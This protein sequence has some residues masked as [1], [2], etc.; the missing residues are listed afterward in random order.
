MPG[1]LI[2][3]GDTEFADI[4]IFSEILFDDWEITQD[5][6]G[7][8]DFNNNGTTKLQLLSTGVDVIGNLDVSGII[9][10]GT[11][12][13]SGNLDMN[14]NDIIDV[15]NINVNTGGDYLFNS[16]SVLNNNTLGNGVINSSL[17][18][19][20]TLTSLTLGG[21][22]TMDGSFIK[23]TGSTLSFRDSANADRLTMKGQFIGIGTTDP[24]VPL[25]IN[26]GTSSDN[27]IVIENGDSG[28]AN[29]QFFNSTTN[30][31]LNSD[32]FSI[33]LGGGET[34]DLRLRE[35]TAMRFYTNNTLRMT[36]ENDG[37][38]LLASGN[39]IT[40][41]SANFIGTNI[42]ATTLGSAVVNSSLTSVGTQ[43][44]DLVMGNNDITGVKEVFPLECQTIGA[45]GYILIDE[46]TYNN[47]TTDTYEMDFD[48]GSGTGDNFA[49]YR[50][51]WNGRLEGDG[52]NP[53]FRF[54]FE[55]SGGDVN[56]ANDYVRNI[57]GFGGSV[58][59]SGQADHMLIGLF[60]GTTT[61]QLSLNGHFT[62]SF[63]S[64]EDDISIIGQS[65]SKT[66]TVTNGF[67]L[68]G[69]IGDGGGIITTATGFRIAAFNIQNTFSRF[70]ARVYRMI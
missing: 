16:I 5:T 61:I 15:G 65:A 2:G 45:L 57:T 20:G 37:D 19:V 40:L 55:D 23:G 56:S 68:V 11:L 21:T 47:P 70:K 32:G 49:M 29:I 58:I 38:M 17:T 14:T 12:T 18:S 35:N 41:T 3:R 33:G 67:N 69:N 39:D 10:F 42:N 34:A 28:S 63:G 36:I 59:F 4:R 31:T 24:T 44:E 30:N 64:S 22:I 52:S 8:L 46:Q 43:A 66:G 60:T 48:L 54:I 53:Q 25:Y 26:M 9:T 27:G 50:V 6:S 51:I 1:R 7:N 13:F 62:I